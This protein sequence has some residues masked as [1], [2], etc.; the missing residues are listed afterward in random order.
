MLVVAHTVPKQKGRSPLV[1]QPFGMYNVC[2]HHIVFELRMTMKKKEERR[3][4][5]QCKM[6][7]IEVFMFSDL[8]LEKG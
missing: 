8:N 5:I 4:E 2:I 6:K 1:E 3:K 7:G